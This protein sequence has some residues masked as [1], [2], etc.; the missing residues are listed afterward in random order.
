MPLNKPWQQVAAVSRMIDLT[1]DTYTYVWKTDSSWKN[2]CRQ[3][4]VK[5]SDGTEHAANFKFK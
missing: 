5:L 2:T 3:L 4:I 1:T